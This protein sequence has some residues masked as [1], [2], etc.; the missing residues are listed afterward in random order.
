[1]TKRACLFTDL[2]KTRR[3]R[4]LEFE[5]DLYVLRYPDVTD[6][7]REKGYDDSSLFYKEIGC[8]LGHSPNRYFDELWYREVH[9]DVKKDLIAGKWA[10][11]FE[12]YC[13]I[14]FL[15]HAPHWLFNEEDYLRKNF[16]LTVTQIRSEGYWNGYDHYLEVGEKAGLAASSFFDLHLTRNLKAQYP[17]WFGEE[18]LLASW[19]VLPPDIAE[20]YPVS[21]YF[22][23][24]WYQQTYPHVKNSISQGRHLNALHHYLTNE[25]PGKFDPSPFFSEEFYLA[26]SPDI[27]PAIQSGAFRNGYEHFVR[28]GAFEGRVPSE[29]IDLKHYSLNPLVRAQCESGLFHSPFAR[30]VAERIGKAGVTGALVPEMSEEQSRSLFRQEADS[31]IPLLAHKP[32][33]FTLGSLAEISV[34]MVVHNQIALTLQTLASLRANYQGNLEVIL[35]D[36]GSKDETCIIERLVHGVTL[37]R[38]ET[39]I[40]YLEGCNAALQYVTAPVILFLNNDLRLFPGAVTHA[41]TRLFKEPTTGAVTAKLVRS[42]MRLQEAGSIIWRDGATYGYRREDDPNIPEANY[43]REVDYGSAAFLMVHTGLALRL[44]GY[45]PKYKPAYFEDTDFCV[46][47]TK[48][49]AKIIYEPLSVVEH[50]EFGT[51]G[52]AGSHALIQKHLKLFSQTHQDFLRHQQPPHI[53]NAILGRETRRKNRKNVLFIEDRMPVKAL[54]SGYVRSNEIICTFVKLGYHVTVFPVQIVTEQSYFLYKEFPDDVELAL[55]QSK[56]TLASFLEERVGYYDILWVA[57]THNL[58]Q[59]LPILSEASRFLVGCKAVLD[60]EVVAAPR[61]LLQKDILGDASSKSLDVLLKEELSGAS[62][63]QQIV[64]VTKQD[65]ALIEQAGYSNVSIL[66][67]SLTPRPTMRRFH[68]RRDILFLGAFHDDQSPNFD[69]MV[70]FVNEVL[71]L[72]QNLPA[73]TMLRIAGYIAPSVNLNA[74]AN[75]PLV[76]IL[77][78]VEDLEPI[79]D[80]HRIFIAPTR[81]AGG[82]PYK[83]HEAASY[84]LPIVATSLLR[85]QVGWSEGKALLSASATDPRGFAAAIE[86]LYNNQDIWTK[87]RENALEAVKRDTDPGQFLK[88]LASIMSLVNE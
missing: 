59:L 38:F 86:K 29:G 27:L 48:A 40:G 21:W 66:G 87:L 43:V 2:Q 34:I 17:E 13:S 75:H 19:L 47:L 10:S 36:S 25:T 80:Q 16:W 8:Y 45:D 84:G 74:I 9:Q 32:L 64:A 1:M 79:Y 83:I 53:R 44:G 52:H 60:T 56:F 24:N 23:P 76:D 71:P 4:W 22:D 11:G 78:P 77:G 67:H 62:Y 26:Q 37:L 12:H 49:G 39:N 82:L 57:R 30:F 51:S 70:W 69:S 15:T 63:C 85:E 72:I 65:A 88:A 73:K 3:P 58:N 61:T 28:F 54:G 35:V 50:L 20:S 41:L 14:G 33:D 7:M 46:R 31:F 68:D 42:N 55:D 18:G 5:P 81:F 6:L